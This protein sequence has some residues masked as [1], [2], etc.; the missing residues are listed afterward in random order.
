MIFKLS[1]FLILTLALVFS[2]QDTTANTTVIAVSLPKDEL[3][4]TGT[5][6]SIM[7]LPSSPYFPN[8]NRE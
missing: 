8:D 2:F 6:V 3:L 4:A 1:F 5:N 7:T